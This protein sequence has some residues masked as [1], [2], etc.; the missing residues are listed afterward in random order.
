MHKDKIAAVIGVEGGH[1]IEES[2]EKLENLYNLGMRYM[3]I[4]WNNSTSWAV[5]AARFPYTYSWFE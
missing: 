1:S 3:T 2:L 5:S 4:T